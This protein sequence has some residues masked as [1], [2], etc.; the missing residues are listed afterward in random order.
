MALEV[1]R[2]VNQFYEARSENM[3]IISEIW[4]IEDD[5]DQQKWTK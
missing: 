1:I 2:I 3:K 5:L 4:K